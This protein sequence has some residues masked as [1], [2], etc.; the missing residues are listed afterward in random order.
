VGRG[1]TFLL[2]IGRVFPAYRP[3]EDQ[4]PMSHRSPGGETEW[5]ERPP[6]R[7]PVVR[8]AFT[9]DDLR[10][11]RL[12]ISVATSTAERCVERFGV[13][14]VACGQPESGSICALCQSQT[15]ICG[16]PS[17]NGSRR[18]EAA[19]ISVATIA[20]SS[21]NQPQDTCRERT[22]KRSASR[23]TSNHAATLAGRD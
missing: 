7:C 3:T 12:L 8:H 6:R 4:I 11:S 16:G 17:G 22:R 1:N 15:S 21:R 20:I 9:G 10:L 19:Q 14:A 2:W 23:Q 18:A 13:A 5:R